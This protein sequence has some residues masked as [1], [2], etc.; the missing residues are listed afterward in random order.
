MLALLYTNAGVTP[1]V[2]AA[3]RG[4]AEILMTM[5]NS[6]QAWKSRCARAKHVEII[7]QVY[8]LFSFSRKT[9]MRNGGYAQ[10]VWVLDSDVL[11]S[12]T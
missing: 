8:R 7:I 3:M 9:G 2:Q 6:N 4:Q 11:C 5:A 1:V 12:R 10:A